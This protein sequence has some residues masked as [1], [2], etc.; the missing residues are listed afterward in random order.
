MFRSLY[1]YTRNISSLLLKKELGIVLH[2]LGRYNRAFFSGQTTGVDREQALEQAMEWLLLAGEHMPDQGIGSFHLVDGW[3]SSY[4]ETSGY[5]IPT[6]IVYGGLTGK[7]KFIDQAMATADWLLSIQ[8][9]SGGWQGGRI[10][11]NKPEIVFNTGQIIRGMLASY[12]NDNNEKYLNAAIKAGDWLQSVQH[13]GGYWKKNALMEAERVYDSYVDVPLLML[14]EATGERR[15]AETA[16]RNLDW[17]VDK[18]QHDNGWFEDC[19]NTL[20][21]N[22]RP[23]LHTIAYTIDGLLDAGIKLNSE[24]YKAAAIKPAAKLK[25]LFLTN[26]YLNGRYDSGWNGSEYM[27]VTGCAQ[28]SIAWMKISIIS[29]DP[30]YLEAAQKMNGLLVR[31]QNR[32]EKYS[33]NTIGA[34]QGSFPIWGKYEPF[35]YPNW[36][37]KYFADALMLEQ[38]I[39]QH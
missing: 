18:K 10:N 8:K 24:K 12:A 16:K 26:G 34:L 11:E 33:S 38:N 5:I 25:D 19:D 35:A 27:I 14:T 4:P 36:A 15:Y 6:L 39:H 23:I 22:D 1:L 9:E 20:K 2:D 21:H 37:T 13:E 3:S 32:Q 31:I 30:S 29:K 28:I 17:I 7:D